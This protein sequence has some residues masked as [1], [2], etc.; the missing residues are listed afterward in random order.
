MT[1]LGAAPNDRRDMKILTLTDVSFPRVNGVS[2]SI[3]TFLKEY[4]Q[5]GHETLLIAPSYEGLEVGVAAS[6]QGDVV[7]IPSRRIPFD[8]EDRFMRGKQVLA[9][10]ASLARQSFDI[11][12]IQTPF[13]AHRVGVRLAARL[14]I[15]AVET[16]HTYF[17]EYF[18]HYVPFMPHS[19]SRMISQR[20]SRRQCDRVDAVV[21]PSR[22]MEKALEDYGVTSPIHRI[23]TGLRLDELSNGDGDGFRRRRGIPPARPVVLNVGRMA[24]EKNLDFLLKV[25]AKVRRTVPDILFMLAGEGPA[26][27]HLRKQVSKL[28]LDDHV[29]FIGYLDRQS[30]LLDCYR[31][32]NAFIFASR[33]ETQGLVLLES[34]ALGV[35]VVSTAVMGTIDILSPKRGAL[36]V[37]EDVSEFSAAV[38][39]LLTSPELQGTLGQEAREYVDEWSAG[40]MAECML[41]LYAS[42]IEERSQGMVA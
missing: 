13:V 35:P 37:P 10:A 36:V 33:T 14:G 40:A 23:P 11:L 30:E 1:G 19:M 28:G 26:I 3:A 4:R 6:S 29:L 34:M 7:R 18:H 31:S 15:P 38:E 22:A 8:P 9:M 39:R 24:F 5:R 25:V 2:T 32:A 42:L 41:D 16:Y 17:Q 21:V 12:H 27:P 20:F